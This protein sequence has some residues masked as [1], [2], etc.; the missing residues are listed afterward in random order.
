[1]IRAAGSMVPATS[2][3]SLC[4][5]SRHCC[6]CCCCYY[7]Q[8]MFLENVPRSDLLQPFGCQMGKTR[9]KETDCLSLDITC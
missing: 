2:P 3:L 4:A 7:R 5:N 8:T 9:P 1:M 6:C